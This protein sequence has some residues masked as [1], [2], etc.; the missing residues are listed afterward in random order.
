MKRFLSKNHR[1]TAAKVRAE[2][3]IHLEYPVSI[4]MRSRF[5]PPSSLSELEDVHEEW[6]SIPL[7]TIQNI[8]EYI[9]RRIQSVLQANG[10]P[11][12][13][14]KNCVSFAPVFIGLSIPYVTPYAVC[15]VQNWKIQQFPF[16]TLEISDWKCVN[17]FEVTSDFSLLSLFNFVHHGGTILQIIKNMCVLLKCCMRKYWCSFPISRTLIILIKIC[18]YIHTY[19]ED[20]RNGIKHW[21]HM[22]CCIFTCL[23]EGSFMN[24]ILTDCTNIQF[25][26]LVISKEDI[27]VLF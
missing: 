6:Y 14:I 1:I 16:Y 27:F 12:L 23:V 11:T 8:Y 15:S 25:W 13:L 17:C 9:P 20:T 10:G 7:E 2:L 24:H 3:I 26:D 5:P 18:T 4:R 21:C 19:T 22:K